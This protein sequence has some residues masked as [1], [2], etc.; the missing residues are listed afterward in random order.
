MPS[1]SNP[2]ETPTGLLKVKDLILT[3][4][5]ERSRVSFGANQRFKISDNNVNLKSEF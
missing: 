2:A 5:F 3:V 1:K 4:V